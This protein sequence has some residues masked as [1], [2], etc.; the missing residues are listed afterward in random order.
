MRAVKEDYRRADL[1]PVDRA[2]LDFAVKL[3]RRPQAMNRG[4]LNGL[5]MH[6]LG[7][8]AI[9]EIVHIAGF[10]NYINRVADALGVDLEPEMEEMTE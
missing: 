5:R 6:G 2:M 10:F 8:E 1:R 7:D 3:T 4:D 9:L